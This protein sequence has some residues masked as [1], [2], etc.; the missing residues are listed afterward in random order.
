MSKWMALFTYSVLLIF[1]VFIYILCSLFQQ[2]HEIIVDPMKTYMHVRFTEGK[3]E[4]QEVQAFL[5]GAGTHRLTLSFSKFP[6]P[7]QTCALKVQDAV[8]SV[9]FFNPWKSNFI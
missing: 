7:L 2:L 6:S 8:I 5:Q 3:H 9:V 1:S 4:L